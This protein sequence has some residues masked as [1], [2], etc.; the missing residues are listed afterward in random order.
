MR[1]ELAGA[2]VRIRLG[3]ALDTRRGDIDSV[4][5]RRLASARIRFHISRMS[6]A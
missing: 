4:Q 2:D 6:S 5:A 3:D 1:L